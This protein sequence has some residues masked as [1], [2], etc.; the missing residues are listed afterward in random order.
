MTFHENRRISARHYTE[1][2]VNVCKQNARICVAAGEGRVTVPVRRYAHMAMA[3]S[4][5]QHR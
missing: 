1:T 2:G 5:H 4:M 3:Q